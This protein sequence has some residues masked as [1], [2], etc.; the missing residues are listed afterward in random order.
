[1]N[2]LIYRG[3]GGYDHALVVVSR[4]GGFTETGLR[5]HILHSPGGF[6]WG[7]LGSGPAELARCILIDYFD[8]H[9]QVEKGLATD[10]RDGRRLA[11]PGYQ[12]FK[13]DWVARWPWDENQRGSASEYEDGT[14]REPAWELTG[15]QIAQWLRDVAVKAGVR[16]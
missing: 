13:A 16:S 11:T 3:Y 12:R 10:S 4:D 9:D 5:H 14:A 8:I 1:M 6:S 7:Y 15:E 2:S